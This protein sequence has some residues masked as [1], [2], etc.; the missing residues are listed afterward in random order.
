MSGEP[1][2]INVKC[3]TGKFPGLVPAL[4]VAAGVGQAFDPVGGDSAPPTR[5]YKG[6][7]DTGASNTVITQKIVDECGLAA[8]GKAKPFGASGQY[9]TDTYF[10]SIVLPNGV[11]IPELAV[12]RGSYPLLATC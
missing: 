10:V 1:V 11:C 8:I 3:C 12:S 5:G 9:E 4:F 2:K 6:I 7:W